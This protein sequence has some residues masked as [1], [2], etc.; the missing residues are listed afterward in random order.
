MGLPPDVFKRLSQLNRQR[1][2]ADEATAADPLSPEADDRVH[3]TLSVA[4]ADLIP[5]RER[6]AESGRFY[7]VTRDAVDIHPAPGKAD[8]EARDR[9]RDFLARYRRLFSGTG[10]A[11]VAADLPET[12]RPFLDAD[13]RRILYMD[14][15]TC[16]LAGE[17]LFLIGL[18]RMDGR[19]LRVD[20]YLARDY[21]EEAAVLRAFWDDLA[22]AQCLVTFNGR[23][24]D[25]P[26]ILKRTA[27][28]RMSRVPPMPDHV[29]LLYES[30]RRWKR[31]LP[32]CRLQTLEQMVCGRSRTG[33]IPSSAIPAAYHEF[34]LAWQGDDPVR[35]G[36]SLRRLQ[37]ILHHNALD[38]VTMAELL[39]HL[40]GNTENT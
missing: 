12:L 5:G 39:V 25:M 18:M 9:A 27:V 30:R 3:A 26:T 37:T 8:K 7:H 13:P 16:G 17:P 36:R 15:E 28:A 21:S 1:L 40:L 2:S 6:Q 4:L 35:R 32:N 31:T 14:I 34:V 11:G 24:F 22:E 10:V 23:S 19:G 38:I 20:Q 29:D 33:D